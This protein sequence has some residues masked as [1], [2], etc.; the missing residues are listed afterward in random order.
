LNATIV[1]WLRRAVFLAGASIMACTTV[2]YRALETVGIEKREILGDRIEEARDAQ[3]AAKDQFTSAL[4]RYRTLINVDGGD[5]EELY[6][7][8][9]AEYER[10][11]SRADVVRDRVQAVEAVAQD[12]FDEWQAETDQYSD[13]ELRR[14]SRRLLADTQRDYRDLMSAMRSAA[15]AMDPVL[16][17]FRD[18][19]LILR[20]SLNARAISSLE[21]ELDDIERATAALIREMERAIAEAST[22]MEAMQS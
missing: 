13:A 1:S 16:T 15:G 8:L 7:R 10:S 2:Y 21:N 11:E 12:L 17:L 9:N 19:V 4:E 6:D 14:Q 3:E 22:F 18:Q 20:H 5:L